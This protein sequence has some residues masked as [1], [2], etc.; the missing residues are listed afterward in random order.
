VSAT[1]QAATW[2]RPHQP[3]DWA[4][5]DTIPDGCLAV[6]LWTTDLNWN[7]KLPSGTW[8]LIGH[9]AACPTTDVQGPDPCTTPHHQR[10]TTR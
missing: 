4:E 2:P 8:R 1:W 3:G 6:C 9:T 7:T 10:A 5:F